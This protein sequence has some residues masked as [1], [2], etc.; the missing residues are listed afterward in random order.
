M[1]SFEGQGG[2]FKPY[3]P[4]SQWSCLRSSLEDSEDV[5]VSHGTRQL[6]PLH[7]GFVEGELCAKAN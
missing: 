1:Q 6:V 2:E 5:R 4:G 3:A 7:A